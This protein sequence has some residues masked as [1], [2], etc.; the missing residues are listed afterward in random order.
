VV[1]GTGAT[2]ATPVAAGLYAPDVGLATG[3]A[4]GAGTESYGGAQL[5]RIVAA[6]PVGGTGPL[7]SSTLPQAIDFGT[8]AP[9]SFAELS[10]DISNNPLIGAVGTNITDLSLL[11]LQFSNA[12]FSGSGFTPTLV[13]GDGDMVSLLLRFTPG[14]S[15]ASLGTL[16][17]GTDQGASFGSTGQSFTFSLL[18]N[19]AVPEPGTW[20]LLF[21][22]F[23]GIGGLSRRRRARSAPRRAPQQA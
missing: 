12:A 15:A 4:C 16:T 23:L 6:N 11:S 7:F 21:T 3:I 18:G 10:F 8:V 19:S 17:I 14:S 9:G 2:S 1:F 22:G 13:L 5:C 20:L